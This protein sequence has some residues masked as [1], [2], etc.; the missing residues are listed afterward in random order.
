[1]G[2][3]SVG[4]HYSPCKKRENHKPCE[5]L[6]FFRSGQRSDGN[7]ENVVVHLRAV[8][9]PLAV[10]ER[11]DGCGNQVDVT[12]GRH[13]VVLSLGMVFIMYLV[14]GATTPNLAKLKARVRG[15]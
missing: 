6:W 10:L 4:V 11:V 14:K 15:F 7:H 2:V 13:D 12:D 1:M 8:P 3:L 5:G 9:V